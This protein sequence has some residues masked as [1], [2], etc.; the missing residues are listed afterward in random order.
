MATTRDLAK[1]A[2]VFLNGGKFNGKRYIS[3]EYVKRRNHKTDLQQYCGHR[4]YI[5]NN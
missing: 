2:S 3:E 1:F 5:R 4:T